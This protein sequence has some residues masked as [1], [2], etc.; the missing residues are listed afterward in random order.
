MKYINTVNVLLDFR[1]LEQGRKPEEMA[2]EIKKGV[3]YKEIIRI[4]A[5]RINDK[6]DSQEINDIAIKLVEEVLK[7]VPNL[8]DIA[9]ERD[10][11]GI[12]VKIGVVL[13]NNILLA[14]A[15]LGFLHG[16]CRVFP[17]VY[18]FTDTEFP[19]EQ[20]LELQDMAR[21]GNWLYYRF[22]SRGL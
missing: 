17:Y 21:R 20:R 6:V 14:V 11:C 13:P 9:Q 19:K 5:P 8:P 10:F 16:I 12:N 4:P 7:K 2:R 18:Y 3:S 1:E 15:I 22:C